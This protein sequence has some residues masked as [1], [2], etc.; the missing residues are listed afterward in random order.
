MY[1]DSWKYT[2]FRD[3]YIM[4]SGLTTWSKEEYVFPTQVSSWYYVK[5]YYLAEEAFKN[6]NRIYA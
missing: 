2:S 1:A 5:H 3:L 4:H 6:V